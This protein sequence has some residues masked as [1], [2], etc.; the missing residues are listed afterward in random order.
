LDNNSSLTIGK[1]F[2]FNREFSQNDFNKF[3][4]ISKDDNPIHID[5]NFSK[6]THFGRTVAHGMFLYGNIYQALES[7]FP[8]SG[9]IQ[10]NQELIFPS[11]TYTGEKIVIELLL[12]NIN[13]SE[14]TYTFETTIKRPN[15]ELGL[16]GS[17]TVMKLK[18]NMRLNWKPKSNSSENYN[19]N[20]IESFKGLKFGQTDEISQKIKVEDLKN[21]L[22]L[23]KSRNMI[24]SNMSYAKSLGLDNLVIPGPLIGGI[25]SQQLGTRLPGKGTNWLRLDINFLKPVYINDEIKSVV[26]ITRIRPEKALINLKVSCYDNSN[27]LVV[28]GE[29]LVLVKDLQISV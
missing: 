2:Y 22:K 25:I 1:R 9:L 20:T 6:R 7:L 14:D 23:L 3:A 26:E 11:P 28:S 8:N 21:Y 5:P 24:Y 4:E 10:L 13:P 16:Q 29:V 27:K 12:A 15:G 18:P 19:S 17:T